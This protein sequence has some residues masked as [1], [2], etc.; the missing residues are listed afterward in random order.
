MSS[1]S[2]PM[3]A[4]G[5]TVTMLPAGEHRVSIATPSQ[6][7]LQGVTSGVASYSLNA[8]VG[9]RVLTDITDDEAGIGTDLAALLAAWGPARD[10]GDLDQ[11]G[12][13]SGTDL[14]MIPAGW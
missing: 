14:A 12:A 13:V 11:D 7:I 8:Y 3:S 10:A 6:C 5:P 9:Y 2:T 4:S 1:Y